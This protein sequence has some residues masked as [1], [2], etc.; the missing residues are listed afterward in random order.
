MRYH[1][2]DSHRSMCRSAMHGQRPRHGVL[3]V[4]VALIMPVFVLFLAALLE[5]GH[6]FWVKHMLTAAARAGARLGSYE[7]VNNVDVVNRVLQ[8]AS[9]AVD[10]SVAL[11][12]IR[13]GSVFDTASVNPG[14]INYETLPALDLSQATSATCFVVQVS[15][16]YDSVALLP[17]FWI[18]NKTVYGRAV[19]RHE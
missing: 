14:S 10:P 18:K 16:P 4:E 8:V 17:P 5:F 1:P 7:G 3:T 19:M 12:I 15:V 13:N 11:V 6:Y 9:V 2:D